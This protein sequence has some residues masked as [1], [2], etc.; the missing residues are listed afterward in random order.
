MQHVFSWKP[1][2]LYSPF[3]AAPPILYWFKA[4]NS[5]TKE[6]SPEKV[7]VSMEYLKE[8]KKKRKKKRKKPH[9][10]DCSAV[11]IIKTF[12]WILKHLKKGKIELCMLF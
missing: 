1:V 3:S 8:K 12:S 7:I 11:L 5:N 10:S 2:P 6:H 9:F 4:N